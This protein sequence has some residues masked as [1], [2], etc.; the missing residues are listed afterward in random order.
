MPDDAVRRALVTGASSGIGAAF[1]RILSERGYE[2]VLVGRD[3]GRL[4][5]VA[6]TL[7][8]PSQVLAADLTLEPDLS[9]V[10]EVLEQ[11]LDV[12]RLAREQRRSGLARAVRGTGARPAQRHCH[13]ECHRAGQAL[14]RST[15][16]DDLQ[17]H[18]RPDQ[19]LE[20]GRR[21]TR[22]RDGHLR[23]DQGIREQLVSVD[24]HGAAGDRGD[25]D[26]CE[27]RLC[28]HRLPHAVR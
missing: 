14:A 16:S 25:G 6:G 27:A 3:G 19:H 15:P 17:R 7:R 1:S 28:S 9:T 21:L 23:R 20:C 13:P 5:S 24:G 4:A 22:R 2:V 26:V 18:W 11:P 12:G 10:E 8:G